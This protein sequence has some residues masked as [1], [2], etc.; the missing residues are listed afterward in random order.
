MRLLL[1][2]QV[3]SLR[4]SFRRPDGRFVSPRN[5]P[6]SPRDFVSGRYT[7]RF[8]LIPAEL[9]WIILEAENVV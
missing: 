5:E 8:R 3:Q 7:M 6:L 2:A 1:P 4:G 9:V